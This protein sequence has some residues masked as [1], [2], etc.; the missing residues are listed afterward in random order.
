[1]RGSSVTGSV[2]VGGGPAGSA[3]AIEL[4]CAGQQVTLIERTTTAA[5]KLCGDF[6]SAEA[7]GRL[8]ALGVDLT[9]AARISTLRLIH[10]RRVAETAL[11]FAACALSRRVLDDALLHRASAVGATV[12]RGHRVSAIEENG[13]SLRILSGSLGR[14]AAD[15]VFLATG[16]HELRST[17]RAWRD[18]SLVGLKMYYRL[19]ARQRLELSGHIELMLFPDGYAGLQPVDSDRAVL[20]LLVQA[21]RLRSTGARWTVL[22]DSLMQDCL[23]LSQRLVGARALLE[24]PLAVANLP[25]GFVYH[26]KAKDDLRLFRLGDQAVV[27]PSLTGA[28]VALALASGSLAARTTLTGAGSQTYHRLFAANLARQLWPARAIHRLS[29]SPTLQPWVLA[30]CRMWPDLVRLVAVATRARHLRDT[31]Y[32]M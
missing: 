10:Q 31:G 8:E 17:T 18:S 27:I 12:L 26:P 1:L 24:R 11:P 7:I 16:K 9:N 20:C 30:V 2:I 15:T 25:Y 21:A 23:H 6:L 13:A 4:A 29:L 32:A 19:D 14:L 3:A 5:E 28:G 22:M